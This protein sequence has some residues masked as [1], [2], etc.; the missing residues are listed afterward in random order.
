LSKNLVIIGSGG[1]ARE[2]LEAVEAANQAGTADYKVLGFIVEARY[3]TPGALVS[4]LPI[5]GDFDW[6]AGRAGEV[7]AVGAVG[8]PVLRYRLVERAARY[9][10]EFGNVI[11][12]GAVIS[13]SVR[14]GWGVIVEAGCVLTSQVRLGDHTHVNLA[15]SISHDTVLDD[16]ATLSPGVH[17]AGRVR[18]GEG[19]FMGIGS[20]VIEGKQVGKWSVIGAGSVVIRDIPDRVTAVGVPT[21]IISSQPPANWITQSGEK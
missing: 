16:F 3:G 12:P 11:H 10:I 19:C 13:S 15:C 20:V 14:L 17:L 8:S 5:L 1:D 18:L 9:N 21:K 6:F 7:V 2:T 4:G